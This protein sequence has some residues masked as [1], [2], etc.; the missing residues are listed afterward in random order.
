MRAR[1][2]VVDTNVVVEGLLTKNSASPTA[3]ILDGMLAGAF[4][5]ILSPALLTEYRVVL[6][7]PAIARRH[8]RSADDIDVLLTGITLQAIV[9]E[10]APAGDPHSAAPDAGDQ[11][12]WDLLAASPGAILVTGD[13]ALLRRAPP[14]ASA[15]SP[16]GFVEILDL[17]LGTR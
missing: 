6:L 5:F 2:A 8:R 11:H 16:A 10:T 1:P 4:P 9:R 15:L 12:L 7:R 3:R 13:D 17:A 14:L